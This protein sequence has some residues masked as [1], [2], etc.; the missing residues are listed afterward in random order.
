MIIAYIVA[1]IVGLIG[2]AVMA[3][4]FLPQIKPSVP[5]PTGE[6]VT[7]SELRRSRKY[8][9]ASGAKPETLADFDAA[10]LKLIIEGDSDA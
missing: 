9:V 6:S 10:L 1:G 2:L 5:S 4:P 8:L 7:L 3:S